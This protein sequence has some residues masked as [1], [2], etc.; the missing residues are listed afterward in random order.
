MHF[1]SFVFT[2]CNYNFIYKVVTNIYSL[3][4]YRSTT[5]ITRCLEK[6]VP[7]G[8]QRPWFVVT[9]TNVTLSSACSLTLS[10]LSYQAYLF[11]PCRICK[12]CS[13]ITFPWFPIC[14]LNM[15][16]AHH[17]CLHCLSWFPWSL[18]SASGSRAA[19]CNCIWTTPRHCPG[20]YR[21]TYSTEKALP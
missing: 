20:I 1:A 2:L 7:T 12:V 3:Q 8:K 13:D 18:Y 21:Q 16:K 10:S 17:W 11:F 19:S 4:I 14:L 15:H 6:R 5:N 9:S